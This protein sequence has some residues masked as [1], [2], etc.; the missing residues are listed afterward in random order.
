MSDKLHRWLLVMGMCLGCIPM[1]R[2][3][4]H[5]QPTDSL[6]LVRADSMLTQVLLRYGNLSPIEAVELSSADSLGVDTML[7]DCIALYK[8]H[9]RPTN[10]GYL[11]ALRYLFFARHNHEVPP[12][13]DEALA[14]SPSYL[15]SEWREV[16]EQYYKLKALQ[17]AVFIWQDLATWQ[18]MT[19]AEYFDLAEGGEGYTLFLINKDDYECAK[20]GETEGLLSWQ[21]EFQYDFP[22]EEISYYYTKEL[23]PYYL[24]LYRLSTAFTTMQRDQVGYY[25]FKSNQR[26]YAQC[27]LEEACNRATAHSTPE[28]IRQPLEEAMIYYQDVEDFVK[29]EVDCFS[30]CELLLSLGRYD[31]AQ[32]RLE[33]FR[34]IIRPMDYKRLSVYT[35]LLTG[36]GDKAIRIL[37]QIYNKSKNNRKIKDSFK[38]YDLTDCIRAALTA[39]D[40]PKA[41]KLLWKKVTKYSTWRLKYFG[42]DQ[43][44]RSLKDLSHRQVG[45]LMLIE[46]SHY[47]S[48]AYKGW[49]S[50]MFMYVPPLPYTWELGWRL[51]RNICK[52]YNV[53]FT[54]WAETFAPEFEA[55]F[56]SL[57]STK[58]LNPLGAYY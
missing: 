53:T 23:L 36:K 27:L 58:K 20:V 34:K 14:N 12:K 5:T 8:Q 54:D 16:S 49:N 48:Y 22:V 28:E 46:I 3:Q 29:D 21:K 10:R 57:E 32:Q 2:A 13:K 38:E 33:D 52:E 24:E 43:E 45:E 17:L 47:Y 19:Y 37:E 30:Y 50:F 7:Q 1:L 18:D 41:E 9:A 40:F 15:F 31:E 39:G 55:E 11:L 6:M 25:I 51:A 56:G 35:Y 4:Q 26:R 44:I 42:K